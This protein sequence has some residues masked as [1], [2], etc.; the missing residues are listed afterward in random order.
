MTAPVNMLLAT[1]IE[2]VKA[3]GS[4]LIA[5]ATEHCVN[6]VVSLIDGDGENAR[7]HARAAEAYA[8]AIEQCAKLADDVHAQPGALTVALVIGDVPGYA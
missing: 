7:L 6:G 5:K 8:L 4:A 1:E 2:W 3:R